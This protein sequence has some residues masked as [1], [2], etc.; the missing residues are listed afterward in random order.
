VG[1]GGGWGEGP[2]DIYQNNHDIKLINSTLYH[3]MLHEAHKDLQQKKM[4]YLPESLKTC[5][6][7]AFLP[8]LQFLEFLA[9][10]IMSI[11]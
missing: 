5:L 9:K 1:W 11:M 3:I 7:M 6:K 4:P 10:M 8:S 2:E